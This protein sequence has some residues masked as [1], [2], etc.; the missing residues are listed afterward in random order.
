ME[1]M[2]I[3]ESDKKLMAQ[4]TEELAFRWQRLHKKQ[5]NKGRSTEERWSRGDGKTLGNG[6]RSTTGREERGTAEQRK[7]GRV[8][9]KKSRVEKHGGAEK[10][11]RVEK[12]GG[13]EKKSRVEKHGGAEKKSRVEKHGGAEKKSRVEKHKGRWTNCAEKCRQ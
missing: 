8:S 1:M 7:C 3:S 9:E 13:A 2:K 4:E 5:M 10:K 12:H 11:S 6:R